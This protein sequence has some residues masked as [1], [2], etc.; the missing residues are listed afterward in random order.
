MESCRLNQQP[1]RTRF[2]HCTLCPRSFSNL[3]ALEQHTRALHQYTNLAQAKPSVSIVSA[4]VEERLEQVTLKPPKNIPCIAC[5]RRFATNLALQKHKQALHEASL[6]AHIDS[7]LAESSQ[8]GASASDTQTDTEALQ[9]QL[10]A[11]TISSAEQPATQNE[12]GDSIKWTLLKEDAVDD[13]WNYAVR[14]PVSPAQ[15][16]RQLLSVFVPFKEAFLLLAK[17]L[18][19]LSL[20]VYVKGYSS[21]YWQL[22]PP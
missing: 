13:G 7:T 10:E 20:I 9:S 11:F 1:R 22:S 4:V 8:I 15:E 16:L 21:W 18:K 5:K 14:R 3:K 19:I 12:P 2:L 17:A 6:H